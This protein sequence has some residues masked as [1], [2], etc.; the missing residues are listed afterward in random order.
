MSKNIEME[1]TNF[2]LKKWF[3]D[4]LNE[5]Q[6][7]HFTAIIAQDLGFGGQI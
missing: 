2:E 3:F 6:K 4:N 5:R 1:I 7:R